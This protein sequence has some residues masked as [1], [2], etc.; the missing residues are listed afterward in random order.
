MS[1]PQCGA[2]RFVEYRPKNFVSLLG[3]LRLQRGYYH[4]GQC[5][6][7]PEKDCGVEV[8]P[9]RELGAAGG[10]DRHPA[11]SQPP[12][13]HCQQ[14]SGGRHRHERRARV[15]DA[16]RARRAEDAQYPAVV[17]PAVGAAR[18]HLGDQDQPDERRDPGHQREWVVLIDGNNTQI[19]AVTAEA[20]RRGVQVTIIIDLCRAR[21]YADSRGRRCRI[22]LRGRAS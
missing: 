16:R 22:A 18:Q 3:E 11:R 13:E 15:D 10:A 21:N 7:A 1:C 20:E 17:G 12:A 5:G 8:E 9:A 2:A 6:R 14:R 19:D 4:C